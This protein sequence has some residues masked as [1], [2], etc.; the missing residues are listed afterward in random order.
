MG[1]SAS[2]RWRFLALSLREPTRG[3]YRGERSVEDTLDDVTA[4]GAAARTANDLIDD[5]QGVL[6]TADS[7]VRETLAAERQALL[8]GVDRQRVQTLTYIV[9]ERLAVLAAARSERI[10]L[11]EALRQER[12]AVIDALREE[13]IA[14]LKEVDAI[15]SR[16]V[17]AS[18]AGL[19]DLVDYT[20]WR[21]AALLVVLMVV[22]A[23]LGI[24]GYR[25]TRERPRVDAVA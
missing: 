20:L 15:K 21:V 19:R 13:R 18:V 7:S 3:P 9:A 5:T 12:V 6:S 2:R 25:L 1:T 8:E 22:A 10:A 14:G 11:V 4:I 24:V 17:D 16:A 23:A